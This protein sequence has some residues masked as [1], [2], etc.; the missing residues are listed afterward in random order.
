MIRY[1]RDGGQTVGVTLAQVID[2]AAE[3]TPASIR[4]AEGI[5][6]ASSGDRLGRIMRQTMEEQSGAYGPVRA[7]VQAKVDDLGGAGNAIGLFMLAADMA[8]TVAVGGD[9]LDDGDRRELRRLWAD[10][11]SQQET[12]LDQVFADLFAS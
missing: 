8:T 11:R 2:E 5:D 4:F 12:E 6:H 10:L 1:R 3:L 7:A 9:Q